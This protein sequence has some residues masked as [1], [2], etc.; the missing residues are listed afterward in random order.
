M[1]KSNK[2]KGMVELNKT[3][4]TA[5]DLV[6]D[7]PQSIVIDKSIS[8]KLKNVVAD[9][10]EYKLSST[11]LMNTIVNEWLEKNREE[12]ISNHILKYNN[13]Y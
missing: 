6:L 11:K 5:Q 7:N 10:P 8:S 2:E 13:R 1:T 4:N 12:L 3:L 9:F